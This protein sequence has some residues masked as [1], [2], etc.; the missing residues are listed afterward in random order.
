VHLLS[1]CELAWA[2]LHVTERWAGR[3]AVPALRQGCIA[4]ACMQDN[5]VG[6]QEI[7]RLK[8]LAM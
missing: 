6:T 3:T 7:P 2:A 1:V 8:G 4:R 5:M